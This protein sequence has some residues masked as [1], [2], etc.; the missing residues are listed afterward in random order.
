MAINHFNKWSSFDRNKLHYLHLGK[1]YLQKQLLEN[2]RYAAENNHK[3]MRY[4]TP[5]TAA[6]I[7]GF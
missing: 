4:P 1:N 3:I 2:L 5:E 7:E 6:K